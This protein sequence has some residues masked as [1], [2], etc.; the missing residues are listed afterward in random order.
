MLKFLAAGSVDYVM[1]AIIGVMLVLI[2]V[3]FLKNRS[4]SGDGNLEYAKRLEAEGNFLKAKQKGKINLYAPTTDQPI[5]GGIM[6]LLKS[7]PEQNAAFERCVG[8]LA[9]MIEKY[10]GKVE[11]P[12]LPPDSKTSWD[13]LS[14]PSFQT[15]SEEPLTDD[16]AA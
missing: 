7:T 12:A 13:S 8:F 10:S 1:L 6:T 5:I 14:N 16:M 3:M 15:N 9:E 2:V 11:I 4:S